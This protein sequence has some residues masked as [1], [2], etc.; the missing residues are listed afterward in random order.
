[1]RLT[2]RGGVEHELSK[3]V[4]HIRVIF[5]S[6]GPYLYFRK[7]ICENNKKI[8]IV[9][10]YDGSYFCL[11]RLKPMRRTLLFYMLC[12]FWR[13][14]PIHQSEILQIFS[15]PKYAQIY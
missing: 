14:S 10:S 13:N 9:G 12:S 5:I 4:Q 2:A 3:A 7:I 15:F 1:M 8:L 6:I 11:I